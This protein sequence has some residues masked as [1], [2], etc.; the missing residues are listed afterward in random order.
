M[1]VQDAS[2]FGPSWREI[3]FGKP[4]RRAPWWAGARTALLAQ[5]QAGTPRYV[6]DLATVRERARE[7]AAT[8]AVD[9]CFYA[10]KA[11]PHP[12]ILR[13]LV[14]EGFGLECVSQGELDH[15]FATLP[16]L[17][18]Q[19]VLFTPSFAPRRE[20]EA[21]FARGVTVTLD[22]L[23]ALQRWPE[24]F[25][26]RTLWLRLDLGHGEGHHEK[27]RTGGVAA[28]FGLP[29]AR[30]DAFVAQARTLDVRIGGLHAHLGSGIDDPGH[31]REVYANLA[32][33]A[34]S[35]GTIETIDIGGG[36]PI[37]YTPDAQDFDLALW[38]SGLDEIKA[39]YPRYG[40]VI[41]PGRYLVAESGVLLLAVT[42][43]VEKD[44]VR[45]IGCDAGMN[46]LLRPAM[47]EAW[48]GIH[49]LSRP[50]DGAMAAFDVVGPICETGDVLGER[51]L[52]PAA[53]AEGDIVLV[54]DAGAYGMAMANTYNLRALPAEHALNEAAPND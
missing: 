32:G 40:L 12:A 11:N 52:L 43:V 29:L 16:Q 39:A 44:G 33:L 36:L 18:P 8:A 25:R 48:H 1:P 50:D 3:A 20:Y 37:P 49:N 6:Y 53:T 23:E 21:A 7:L 9:R 45:R 27:V 51:R 41:E 24:L 10:I 31:W 2:V 42:Q 47:Y 54:A 46:A 4:A 34:D 5:A 26:G 38:R 35:V 30:F 13:T 28:K 19:R 15:V 22:N 17:A 14:N